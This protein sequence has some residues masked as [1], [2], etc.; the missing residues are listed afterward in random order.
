MSIRSDG[1]VCPTRDPPGQRSIYILPGD[2]RREVYRL[3][4]FRRYP[5]N[6][7][8]DPWAIARAGFY[9]TG[10]RD[11]VKCSRCSRQV[12][13]WQAGEDPCAAK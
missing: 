7:P 9:Y 2:P 10:Y 3:S 1:Y 8:N 5:T 11:R 6:A 12:A 4:T 13:D